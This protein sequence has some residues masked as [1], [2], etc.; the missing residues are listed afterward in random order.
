MARRR[1]RLQYRLAWLILCLAVGLT[2][3]CA[4]PDAA[5]R[6]DSS[7]NSATGEQTLPFRQNADR[8]TDDSVHPAVPPPDHKSG[9]DTPFP[10]A[11]HTRSIPAGTLITVRLFNSLS[12]SSVRPGDP[13]TAFLAGPLSIDGDTLIQSGT[14][15]SGRVESAQ[16]S[17]DR[18]GLSPDPGY[19]RLALNSITI[20][21]R[22]LDLQT[23]SLF[24][25]GTFQSTRLSSASSPGNGSGAQSRDLRLQKG[26]RL[27]F[28][29]TA[30]V[31]LADPN[32]IANRQDPNTSAN[33]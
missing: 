13:F 27:T 21:G 22:P 29:L 30:P 16:P 25:K 19:I 14:L 33:R 11:S 18:P 2:Q 4:R 31:L 28:R 26:R 6:T 15:V 24:A 9:I 32:S 5:P 7:S 20:D 1:A 17:I 23:S 3:G 12:I 10:A 8:S